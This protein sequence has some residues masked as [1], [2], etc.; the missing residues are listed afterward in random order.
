MTDVT[1]ELARL[2][3]LSV[4][5]EI[6]SDSGGDLVFLPNLTVLSGGASHKVD[7][8]L[9]PGPRNGYESRLYF[10]KQL[11][12]GQNWT[13]HSIMARSWHAFS[14]RGVQSN[15]PWLDILASHLEA[16]K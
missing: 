5:A 3:K 12:V 11:P 13:I 6:W 1:A 10:S 15:Q 9:S 8:L 16:A 7:A 2:K 4:R 14:W